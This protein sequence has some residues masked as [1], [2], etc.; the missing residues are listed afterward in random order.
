MDV[1]QDLFSVKPQS[2]KSYKLLVFESD[3]VAKI[4]VEKI[5]IYH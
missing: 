1:R 4:P 3:F 2:N 5:R